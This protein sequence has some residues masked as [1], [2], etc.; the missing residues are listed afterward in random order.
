M[1]A[2]TP[3]LT[4]EQRDEARGRRIMLATDIDLE[5][6]RMFKARAR[7]QAGSVKAVLEALVRAYVDGQIPPSVL[8]RYLT[9]RY[10]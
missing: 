5:L 6:R 3:L 7:A 9:R 10:D 1:S 8:E 4:A 2:D